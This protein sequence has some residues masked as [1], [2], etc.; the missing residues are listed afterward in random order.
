MMNRSD[1]LASIPGAEDA[2]KAAQKRAVGL[3]QAADAVGVAHKAA[4]KDAASKA[5]F[6]EMEA[7]FQ[8]LLD[9]YFEGLPEGTAKQLVAMSVSS[10]LQGDAPAEEMVDE[11][12]VDEVPV[13]EMALDENGD[14]MVE[15]EID[16]EEEKMKPR[17]GASKAIADKQTLLLDRLLTTQTDILDQNAAILKAMASVTA[18]N[19]ALSERVQKMAAQLSLRPRASASQDTL[20][21]SD[22]L[23]AAVKAAM[24]AEEP[25]SIYEKMLTG[26]S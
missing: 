22:L 10:A 15:E 3:Q 23:D 25:K 13:E 24:Q 21:T 7:E 5:I 16:I 4:T 12:A 17:T 19:K 8:A 18:E 11:V 14:P 26:N 6:N 1:V 20:V 2:L 9:K